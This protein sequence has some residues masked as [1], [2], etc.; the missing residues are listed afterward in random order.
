MQCK[1][2]NAEN[3]FKEQNDSIASVISPIRQ[4]LED[5]KGVEMS[6]KLG[7]V[8]WTHLH[9]IIDVLRQNGFEI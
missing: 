3:R 7:Q 9:H 8:L 4:Q 1:I 5:V 2:A 6:I